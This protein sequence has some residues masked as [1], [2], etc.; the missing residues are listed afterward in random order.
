[1]VA[2]TGM[3]MDRGCGRGLGLIPVLLKLIALARLIGTGCRVWARGCT[4]C[5]RGIS[6][7]TEN[8]RVV[9][10]GTSLEVPTVF[11]FDKL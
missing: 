9:P 4:S 6:L 3:A 5:Y 11:V 10:G 1:M 7:P 8:N 2:A